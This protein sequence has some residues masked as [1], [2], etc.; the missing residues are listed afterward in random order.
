MKLQKTQLSSIHTH[1]NVV[2][3]WFFQQFFIW[4]IFLNNFS[5]KIFAV[6]CLVCKG[7]NC[8]NWGKQSN[9]F[10]TNFLR[11]KVL[12]S[13][14]QCVSG[15]VLGCGYSNMTKFHFSRNIFINSMREIYLIDR[16][17]LSVRVFLLRVCGMTTLGSMPAA[18]SL[19]NIIPY[20]VNS[21]GNVKKCVC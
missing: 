9:D 13:Q 15:F 20:I 19:A 21:W 7:V 6:L 17:C 10:H 11:K 12:R 5:R 18:L 16:T 2:Y 14:L 1:Y 8:Q 3:N 4:K